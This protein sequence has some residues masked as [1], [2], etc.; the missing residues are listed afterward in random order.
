MMEPKGVFMVLVKVVPM[1][2]YK[3]ELRVTNSTMFHSKKVTNILRVLWEH[4]P[5]TQDLRLFN[6]L[7]DNQPAQTWLMLLI[8]APQ[9]V[10]LINVDYIF[11]IFAV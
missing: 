1:C 6:I 10:L 7:F 4:E 5:K 11:A 8:L 2:M 3:S 9:A